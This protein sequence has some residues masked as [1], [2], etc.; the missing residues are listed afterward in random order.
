MHRRM[1]AQV[2]DETRI[3]NLTIWRT[4]DMDGWW[5][6]HFGQELPGYYETQETAVLASRLPG[7]LLQHLSNTAVSEGR[8]VTLA[9]VR[10]AALAAN[11]GPWP[12]T[13]E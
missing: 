7:R 4:D 12:D 10:A 3:G 5:A 11:A 2:N 8:P 1:D 13:S 6:R 9:D